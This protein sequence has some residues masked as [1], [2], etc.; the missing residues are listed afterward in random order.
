MAF[1]LS[2]ESSFMGSLADQR[3][4]DENWR[5]MSRKTFLRRIQMRTHVSILHYCSRNTHLLILCPPNAT[6][7]DS[8]EVSDQEQTHVRIFDILE[9]PTALYSI[10][11]P[12]VD[13]L[14]SLSDKHKVRI[15]FDQEWFKKE[16]PNVDVPVSMDAGGLKLRD[17]LDQILPPLGMSFIIHDAAIK[18]VSLEHARDYQYVRKY[19]LPSFAKDREEKVVEGITKTVSPKL[20][21][22]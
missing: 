4:P 21:K 9:Q 7:T 17:V 5:L 11:S 2:L 16:Q 19:K 1:A 6:A 13:V 18:I 12:L 10:E 22:T 14:Q 8:E 15:V 3:K 20:W